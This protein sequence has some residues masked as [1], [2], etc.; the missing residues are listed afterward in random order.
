MKAFCMP[1]ENKPGVPLV[2]V[3]DRAGLV[4]PEVLASIEAFGHR[5][6]AYMGSHEREGVVPWSAVPY[7][8]LEDQRRHGKKARQVAKE[9]SLFKAQRVSIIPER[10]EVIRRNPCGA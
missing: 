5:A 2:D 8:S 1:G 9:F 6:L 3:L 7:A 10:S 4:L